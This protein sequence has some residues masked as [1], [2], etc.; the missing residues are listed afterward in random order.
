MK[1]NS[2]AYR[3]IGPKAVDVDQM[4]TTIGIDSID[5]LIDQTVPSTIRSAEEMDLAPAM[6]EA[7]FAAHITA[8]GEMNSVFKTYIGMGYHNTVLPGVIQ[9]NILENPGWYTAYTPY[10][11][12]IAQGRLEALM[13]YQT[14]VVDLTGMELANASLLDEA[15]AVA[16]AMSMFYGAMPRAK[17]K[18]GASKFFVDHQTFP[19]SIDLLQTRTTPIGVE[20]VFGDY[21]S[22]EPTEEF[23]GAFVQF[24][25]ANG[26]VEDY[27][28]FA[29]KCNAAE[30][31]LVVAADL[32]SLVLLT[33]PG[34]WGADAV[35]GTTQRFGIPLGYGGPH[36]AYFATKESYKRYIPG[37]I[38]G[39]TID[40]DGNPALRMALQTRE[41]H[42]KRDKATSNIC[43]AQVLLAVMAGAY[44]V[45]HG[46]EGL[47]DIAEEIHRK[48]ATLNEAV[49]GMGLTQHN[50][51]FFD[52][53]KITLNQANSIQVREFSEAAEINFRYFDETTIGIS[54]NETT[55]D[56]DIAEI[57]AVLA[58]AEAAVTIEMEDLGQ[59]I[60]TEL[61]RTS[62]FMTNSVFH[63]YRSETEM[64][65]YLKS[66]E[67]KDLALNHSMISLGSCTMKLNAASEMIPLSSGSWNSLHP[68]VPTEQ[69]SGYMQVI[70]ELERD[71][72]VITGFDA[73]SLQPNS[74]AQG[75]YA[76]LMVIRAY[77]QANGDHHRD[78]ALIPSSAHGTNPASAVMAGMKVVVV[79]CDD[80]GNIDVDDLRSKAEK[81]SEN[82]ASLM[83]TYP[84]T[85]GVF[86]AS[87]KE[88][89]DIIHQHGGQVYMD[90]AN[91]NAQVGLTSPG[92]I[93][94]D[95]CHLNLHKTFA[96]PHGGGGPGMG[97]I[98]CKAHL[99]PFLPQH[100]VI[101]MG[102]E[103]GISSISAAPWGSALILLISYAYIKMLGAEGL[104]DSTKY[105][106]LNAN[107]IK[108]RLAGSFDV[109]YTGE[110]GR[111]AHEMILDCRPFK[112]DAGIE[113][114]DIAKRLMDYGFHAPTVSFPV[115]GTVMVEPTESEGLEELDRFCDAML[116]IRR[117]IGE[118]ETTDADAANNVLKNAPHTQYMICA[119]AWDFPYTR[120][121]AG[122]P[123]PY[124]SDNK[125]WPTVRRVDDAYGDRNLV[126][127]CEP[128][129][130]YMEEAEA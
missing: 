42:I 28:A 127:T 10:Q 20:L 100:S 62:A 109:L 68:Y 117:E 63:S 52:T 113:V 54:I 59:Y 123:L 7:E 119:D 23:F 102:G 45:Y 105:A 8:L 72:A 47:M 32:L 50:A 30:V 46:P 75:E 77:H 64:M 107:Y 73:T 125:F 99:A 91:M 25:N 81:H 60:P 22:F 49:K 16:E 34:H 61:S 39:R 116:S 65:R 21:K 111:C 51:S 103:Q 108:E 92:I 106:I 36:A 70:E 87:V 44:G 101:A 112:R 4:L 71:L 124:V 27:R 56:E 129:E 78:I 76:G 55:T 29:E 58:K 86:E 96:I 128:I 41:Q 9:R 43:T 83:I 38:I 1:R 3:H 66:L 121:K 120:S 35:V 31:Q 12:E 5:T 74:G 67:R 14:M 53:L 94:A 126:C 26:S 122:F 33:P 18:A 104:T 37:R 82:L 130:S 2:F 6:T 69:A 89:T 97:P 13:N 93:G 15:T 90:G 85:H 57:I 17:K 80:H 24:P 48:T 19:Q 88:I 114:T 98:C 115:A 11:A 110:N 118:I 40:T 95:V 84:S 79:A